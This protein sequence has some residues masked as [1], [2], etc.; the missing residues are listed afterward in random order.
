MG[1]VVEDFARSGSLGL[2][3]SIQPEHAM[4]DRDVADH[5]WKGRTD[6]AFAFRSLAR[7]RRRTALRLG[8]SGRSPRPLAGHRRRCRP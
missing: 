2:V 5:Y 6:R 3:A 4:D 7:R 1:A 8:C